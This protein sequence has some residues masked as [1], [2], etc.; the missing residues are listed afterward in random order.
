M[1]DQAAQ[2]RPDQQP[3]RLR[4]GLQLAAAMPCGKRAATRMVGLTAS[5]YSSDETVNSA[6]A[7]RNTCRLPQRSSSQ[8][9][10]GDANTGAGTSARMVTSLMAFHDAR[11]CGGRR[12]KPTL[13]PCVAKHS[14]E[15]SPPSQAAARSPAKDR[16]HRLCVDAT[17]PP[18]C[19]PHQIP[20]HPA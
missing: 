4:N 11:H 15:F 19:P 12:L 17:D 9:L 20:V 16:Q 6:S 18:S 13:G 1:H 7:A 14:T 10:T 3:D 5:P 2:C 8:L